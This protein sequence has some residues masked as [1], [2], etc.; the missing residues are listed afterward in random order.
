MLSTHIVNRTVS[1]G[2][3]LNTLGKCGSLQALVK[4]LDDDR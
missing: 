3:L 1:W 2:N 4:R